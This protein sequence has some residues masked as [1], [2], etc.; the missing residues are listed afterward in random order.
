MLWRLALEG[1]G[2]AG[3]ERKRGR[4]LSSSGALRREDL[5]KEKLLKKKREAPFSPSL[6][7]GNTTRKG[8][9]DPHVKK[10][11][12]AGKSPPTGKGS[13]YSASPNV[14]K[15]EDVP[16]SLEVREKME[17][18]HHA[19]SFTGK[20]GRGTFDK[21]SAISIISAVEEKDSL[22]GRKAE[23]GLVSGTG[24]EEEEKRLPLLSLERGDEQESIK[25]PFSNFVFTGPKKGEKKTKG[26]R[27]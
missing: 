21:R 22:R 16:S 1:E 4:S 18:E 2:S 14:K 11:I 27:M 9:S 15:K 19:I 13:I 6:G 26:K 17:K 10:K 25:V 5:R 12:S 20:E 3:E 8:L 23:R 7:R 24:R